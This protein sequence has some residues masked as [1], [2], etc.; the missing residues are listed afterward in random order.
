M[1]KIRKKEAP[2]RNHRSFFLIR[3]VREGKVRM[4]MQL[5]GGVASSFVF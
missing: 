3:P 5:R 4:N 1:A 2:V